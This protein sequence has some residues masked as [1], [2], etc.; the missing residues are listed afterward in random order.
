M[1]ICHNTLNWCSCCLYQHWSRL[2]RL[3]S[4]F[5]VDVIL[6]GGSSAIVAGKKLTQLHSFSFSSDSWCLRLPW[7]G[8]VSKRM[9]WVRDDQETF[10]QIAF[11]SA[12][13]MCIYFCNLWGDWWNIFYTSSYFPPKEVWVSIV[14]YQFPNKYS[15][16][17]LFKNCSVWNYLYLACMEI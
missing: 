1:D 4:F 11:I 6:V 7:N 3:L 12:S 14:G 17:K 5:Y 8:V 10:F 15:S 16:N 9:E 2:S 13:M